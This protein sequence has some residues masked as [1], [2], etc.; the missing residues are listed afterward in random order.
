MQITLHDLFFLSILIA[1]VTHFIL[2]FHHG[3]LGPSNSTNIQKP[4]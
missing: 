3:L 1:S 2:D 4:R